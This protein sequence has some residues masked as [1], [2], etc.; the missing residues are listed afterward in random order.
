[1][2]RPK[3]HKFNTLVLIVESK[4]IIQIISRNSGLSNVYTFL[5]AYFEG[6]EFYDVRKK[7]HLKRR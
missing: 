7:V 2:N 5:N 1:M 4:N 3:S 6:V